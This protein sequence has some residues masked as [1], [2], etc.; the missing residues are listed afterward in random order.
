[1]PE[2][3]IPFDLDLGLLRVRQPEG[4][5]RLADRT[6]A[7]EFGALTGVRERVAVLAEEVL[8]LRGGRQLVV[9]GVGQ[10]GHGVDQY[11]GGREGRLN[12]MGENHVDS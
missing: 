3:S 4:A 7:V 9:P 5:Q 11:G 6:D 1:L 12:V 8:Q 10:F 2:R